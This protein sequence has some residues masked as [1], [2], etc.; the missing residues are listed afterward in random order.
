MYTYIVLLHH[1]QKEAYRLKDHRDTEIHRVR[2]ELDHR[3]CHKSIPLRRTSLPEVRM[4]EAGRVYSGDAPSGYP[5]VAN[6][7][8][9][10]AY[11][12]LRY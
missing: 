5:K 9:H 4:A 11:P 10:S 8:P 1:I 12:Y 7:R 3:V 6:A 2:F